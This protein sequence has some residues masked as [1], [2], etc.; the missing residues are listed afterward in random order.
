MKGVGKHIK[1]RKF[2]R[3]PIIEDIEIENALRFCIRQLG[4]YR[5]EILQTSNVI[6]SRILFYYGVNN[7]CNYIIGQL[8]R[9]ATINDG[10]G[11]WL[12]YFLFLQCFISSCW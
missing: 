6:Y 11:C 8:L 4:F 5:N 7:Y 3:F 10:V 1:E 9:Y 2:Y 12:I